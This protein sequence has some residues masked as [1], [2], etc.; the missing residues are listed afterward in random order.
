[1]RGQ[2]CSV[3]VPLGGGPAGARA[4]A[5]TRHAGGA[6]AVAG[7]RAAAGR[8]RT[9]GVKGWPGAGRDRRVGNLSALEDPVVVLGDAAAVS[10]S[11]RRGALAAVAALSIAPFASACGTGQDPQTL[12]VKPDSVATTVGDIEIQNAF[13]LTEPKG[14]GAAVITGRVFNNGTTATKLE[15]VSVRG[16]AD[17]VTLKGANGAAG[18]ITIPAGG[19]VA[20]GGDGN[21]V[22]LL[23]DSTGVR[24]GDFQPTV[25]TFSGSGDVRISPAVVPAEHYF[26]PYGPGVAATPSTVAMPSTLPS[27]S[28]SAPAG[29]PSASGSAVPGAGASGSPA[30]GT[31]MKP[32][33]SGSPKA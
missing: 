22:A 27:G 15:S 5:A 32:V 2:R 12:E 29:A 26:A 17:Q 19:S 24:P 23:A 28:A 1:M 25:F 9:G 21:P 31:T 8:R 10:R 16:A 6:A 3:R 4:D 13:I 11:L 33:T 30:S 7:R 14:G 18:P 20:L